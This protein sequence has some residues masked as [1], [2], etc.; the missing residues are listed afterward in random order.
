MV[1]LVDFLIASTNPIEAPRLTQA[2][3]FDF[4]RRKDPV[5]K[6][7][8]YGYKCK[9]RLLTDRNWSPHLSAR[10]LRL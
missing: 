4:G 8:P 7:V 10:L 3:L 9:E 6:E 1:G 5:T 2:G